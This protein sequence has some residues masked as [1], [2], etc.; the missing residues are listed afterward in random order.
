VAKT[1]EAQET[2]SED[3]S[4]GQKKSSEPELASMLKKFKEVVT[5][6]L[7]PLILQS[8]NSRSIDKKVGQRRNPKHKLKLKKQKMTSKMTQEIVAMVLSILEGDLAPE[9][10]TLQHLNPYDKP[11]S[12]SALEE[13]KKLTTVVERRRKKLSVVKF[14]RKRVK[15]NRMN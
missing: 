11:T 1:P 5:T 4:S 8:P 3:T 6:P 9:E 7:E 2:M 10:M 13:C 14:A 12:S 15:S